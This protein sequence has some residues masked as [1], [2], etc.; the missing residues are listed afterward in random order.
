M[1]RCEIAEAMA[2]NPDLLGDEDDLFLMGLDSLVMMTLMQR[3]RQRGFHAEF[4]E[5]APMPTLGAWHA[6]WQESAT[7]EAGRR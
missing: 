2:I 3:W 7:A 6:L 5:L 4:A 1:L